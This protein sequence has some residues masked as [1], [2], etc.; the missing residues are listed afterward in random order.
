MRVSEAWL[1]NY[2]NPDLDTD[3]LVSQLTMAGLEV[4]SITPAAADF[5]G[6]LIGE[7]ITAEPHPEADRLQICQVNIQAEK[8][9]QIVCGAPNARVGLR[10]PLAV[11]GALLPGGLKI[12][13]TELRGITSEG[14]LCSAKELG[15]DD[16]TN[17]LL[18]L[19]ASAPLGL[20]IR[21]FL[22]LDDNVIEVDLTPNRADCLSME[23]I[24]REV[25]LLNTLDLS[26]GSEQQAVAVSC[27]NKLPVELEAPAACPRYLGRYIKGINRSQETPHWLKERLRRSGIRSLDPVVDVTN[28][29]LIE[30]GQPLH[31]FDADQVDGGI[32]VRMARPG[33]KIALLNG[34]ELEL[35]EDALVIADHNKP[36]ALAGIMGG[37]ESAVSENTRDIFLESA[38]F[39][40]TLIAGKARR[41]GL[42]TDSS[43]R[44]ERGV[45]PD[46]QLRAIERA[47]QLI[48]EI[49]GGSA[50]PIQ[51]VVNQEHLPKRDTI[52]V[53]RSRISRI[54]GLEIE[55]DRI[56]DILTR[57][58]FSPRPTEEG[59]L[60]TPPGFR[61]DISIEADIIE[62]I[63]RVYGY[64]HLPRKYPTVPIAMAE[65]SEQQL[66]LDRVKDQ[67][68][69]RGYQEAI[70]Y[71]FVEPGLQQLIEPE[72]PHLA[73]KNP[74]SNELSIMRTTLWTGL[75]DT[76]IK[77]TNRQHNRIRLFESG[78]KFTRNTDGIEQKPSIA[79]LAIGSVYPEQWG[80]GSKGVDFY[81]IKGD[82]EALVALTGR[83]QEL[84]FIPGRHSA[85]HPGQTAEIRLDGAFIGWVGMLH[86]R[87]EKELGFEQKLFLF[88]L[89][90]E[91]LLSRKVPKFK[92]LSRFPQMRRDI[93]VIVDE[94]VK[95]ADLVQSVRGQSGEILRE[96]I[97]FDV[98]R[99]T[100]VEPGRKSIALG[101]IWQDNAETLTDSRVDEAVSKAVLNLT[102]EFDA[103]LR[104]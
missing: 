11:E 5:K 47:S 52:L 82:I 71:S 60:I 87:L 59:W 66:N 17:G 93:A 78:L 104:D 101:L 39:T 13:R 12:S 69:D 67:L 35:H 44:Y 97:L 54:L 64:N 65:E 55:P 27:D 40:P 26:K 76:A 46:L 68:V 80:E 77:N 7:I 91:K 24:A 58:N 30:L 36:L 81:D 14:M 19:P 33:E 4:D 37:S 6:V 20:N 8:P 22:G 41:Y 9:L 50:G 21:D 15:I 86:P 90:Q 73:L 25:A 3:Q 63:G 45:D 42:N 29:V 75:L 72:I 92:T 62:E 51:H 38:F 28:Y 48:M 74:I 56:N 88:E 79:G 70:T 16:G 57:L 34:Q 98:Y 49:A 31:A 99:G 32:V 94:T 100:G 95:V 2:V 89:D 103:H 83:S 43:H 102:R 18:E 23:G 85:L 84:E 53:R 10:A 61:F 96:I 1:R